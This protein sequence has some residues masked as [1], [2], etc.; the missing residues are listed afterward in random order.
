VA[1]K[2]GR[3]ATPQ[4]SARD[5]ADSPRTAAVLLIGNELLSGKVVDANAKYLIQPE[6]NAPPI[7]TSRW[8]L[9]LKNYGNLLVRTGHYTPLPFGCSPLS[10]ALDAYLLYG[11]I[12][13]DK[14]PD[15]TQGS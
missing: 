4:L 14:R 5:L 10:R 9:L 1:Q 3:A 12:N 2:A 13:L 7:D 11:I 15:D 6:E 8:P